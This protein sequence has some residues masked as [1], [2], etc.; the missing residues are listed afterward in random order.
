MSVTSH[1]HRNA[2][3]WAAKLGFRAVFAYFVHASAS[4]RALFQSKHGYI[5]LK[6]CRYTYLTIRQCL[7]ALG[8]DLTTGV[9]SF[10]HYY[11]TRLKC[12]QSCN[13]T[14]YPL[15]QNSLDFGY[16][17]PKVGIQHI[18]MCTTHMGSIQT[19]QMTL[20]HKFAHR[21]RHF[22]KKPIVMLS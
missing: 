19:A 2:W 5:A 14:P 20:T 21:D 8:N 3:Y 10:L 7:I 9:A 18:A 16:L 15:G 6:L 11:T 4:S 12:V 22:P 1:G 17:D 13:F